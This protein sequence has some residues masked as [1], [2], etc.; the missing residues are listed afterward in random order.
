MSYRKHNPIPAVYYL[1]F[2]AAGL[3]TYLF[4]RPRASKSLSALTED[5]D[6]LLDNGDNYDPTYVDPIVVNYTPPPHS[7]YDPPQTETPAGEIPIEEA[8]RI[9]KNLERLSIYGW[10]PSMACSPLSTNGNGITYDGIFGR[11]SAA[12]LIAYRPIYAQAAE[13]ARDNNMGSLSFFATP[14]PFYDPTPSDTITLKIHNRPETV[15]IRRSLYDLLR[16]EVITEE[17]DVLLYAW[18]DLH[19]DALPTCVA[20]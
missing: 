5:R 3:V 14:S 2:A 1:A 11:N 4:L 19:Y 7:G 13:Y 9:Q 12:Y 10:N 15:T 20:R 17:D 16:S 6:A 18:S 8:K